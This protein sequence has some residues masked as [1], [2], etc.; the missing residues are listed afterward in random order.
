MLL[1]RLRSRVECV[2]D[3]GSRKSKQAHTRQSSIPGGLALCLLPLRRVTLYNNKT[4][5]VPA[6][7]P[8]KRPCTVHH[9][10]KGQCLRCDEKIKATYQVTEKGL[11]ALSEE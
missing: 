7:T 5:S 11:K 10:V 8:T 1:R 3:V 2:K 4:F 6:T 9:F